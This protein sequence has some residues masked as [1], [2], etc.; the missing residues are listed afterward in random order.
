M[1]DLEAHFGFEKPVTRETDE[2]SETA[3]SGFEVFVHFVTSIEPYRHLDHI[4]ECL[5]NRWPHL[6][7]MVGEVIELVR[8]EKAIREHSWWKI[9]MRLAR[10][11]R[12]E[13]L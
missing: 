7:K 1:L 9:L 11:T 2:L 13:R 3:S 12:D 8:G 4:I 6:M 5:T 10:G